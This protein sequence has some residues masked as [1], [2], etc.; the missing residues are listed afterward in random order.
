MSASTS[1]TVRAHP[2]FAASSPDTWRTG[3]LSIAVAVT[4]NL[5]ILGLA[6]LAGADMQVR[7]DPSMPAMTIG[8]GLVAVSTVLPML[9]ASVALLPLRR[10][11][12]RAWRALAWTGLVVG[13]L[14][15]PAPLTMVAEGTTQAALALMHVIAGL[16][17]FVV[18]RRSARA[19]EG[20]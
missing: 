7:P 17:W 2:R 9:L 16:S 13:L 18:V 19:R 3:L 10:W 12:S 4:A 11:G 5:L 15:V 20:G 6:R 14:T 1:S 8:I